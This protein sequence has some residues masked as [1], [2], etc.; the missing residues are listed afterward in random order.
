MGDISQAAPLND[1]VESSDKELE[2]QEH[3]VDDI[4]L[5]DIFLGDYDSSD[6]YESEPDCKSVL[7]LYIYDLYF[8]HSCYV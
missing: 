1:L 2:M 7:M 6:D 5:C 3:S 8:G 4:P